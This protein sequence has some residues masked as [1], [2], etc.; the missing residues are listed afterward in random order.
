MA[1]IDEKKRK[2]IKKLKSVGVE[3]YAADSRKNN[4]VISVAKRCAIYYENDIYIKGEEI[5]LLKR[6]ELYKV[7][8]ICRLFSE[9]GI[10]EKQNIKN[11]VKEEFI[12]MP[13]DEINIERE[14]IK[15]FFKNTQCFLAL[16]CILGCV[17]LAAD[18]LFKGM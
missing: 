17:C 7:V 11:A 1:V 16:S 5:R 14:A 12:L 8:K 2:K 10:K 3:V 9:C 6:E 18:M 13:I 15:Y 4:F